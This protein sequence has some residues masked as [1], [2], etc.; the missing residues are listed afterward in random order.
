MR[1]N[2]L[3]VSTLRG[4]EHAAEKNDCTVRALAILAQMPYGAAHRTL[5]L[6][7]RRDCKGL[8]LAQLDTWF[9]D[10]RVANYLVKRVFKPVYK[11]ECMTLS[12]VTW[13][14]PRGRYYVIMT[15]H[16]VAMIDGVLQDS[17]AQYR[18]GRNRVLA[19]YEFVAQ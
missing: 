3:D 16:A 6:L 5:E 11:R 14:F 15:G 18:S 19:I 7:G 10:K 8:T 4:Q 1:V 17:V 13:R 2:H 12:N 9:A